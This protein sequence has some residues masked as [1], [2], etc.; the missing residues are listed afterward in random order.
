MVP[1]LKSCHYK[2]SRELTIIPQLTKTKFSRSSWSSSLSVIPQ[3][4]G[5][6]PQS[7]NDSSKPVHWMPSRKNL[8]KSG[9]L[10]E[11]N[12]FFRQEIFGKHARIKTI[13]GGISWGSWYTFLLLSSSEM[14]LDTGIDRPVLHKMALLSLAAGSQDPCSGHP[15]K[16]VLEYNY[17]YSIRKLWLVLD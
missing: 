11:G 9:R 7:S 6:T 4:S 10:E 13:T 16:R 12:C 17:N 2:Y 1:F 8:I 14:H 15:W 5:P 3:S